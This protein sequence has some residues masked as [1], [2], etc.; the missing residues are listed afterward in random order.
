M[1]FGSVSKKHV[2]HRDVSGA[3]LEK[4]VKSQSRILNV[5]LCVSAGSRILPFYT[6]LCLYCSILFK[7]LTRNIKEQIL[8]SCPHSFLI[9]VLGRSY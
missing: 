7:P 2:L 3:D 9:K 6:P 5:G 1:L 4:V 8:L